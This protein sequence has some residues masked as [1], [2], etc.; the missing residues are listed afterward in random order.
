MIHNINLYGWV[1]KKIIIETSDMV[2]SF[3]LSY[4]MKTDNG[5]SSC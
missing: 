4:A 5:L 1:A 3:Y 2:A